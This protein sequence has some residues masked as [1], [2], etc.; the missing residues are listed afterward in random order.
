MKIKH[1][2][3]FTHGLLVILSLF[4]VVYNVWIFSGIESDA[5]IINQAGKLRAFSYNMVFIANRMTFEEESANP[6]TFSLNL[7]QKVEAFDHLLDGLSEE[8]AESHT[9]VD[10]PQ[11]SNQLSQ[12]TAQWRNVFKPNYM[13]IAKG[14]TDKQACLTIN[15]MI[16]SYVN[17]IDTMV[18]T[19]SAYSKQKVVNA[20]AVNGGLVGV[21]ILVTLYSFV[22]TNQRIRKPMQ[23]LMKA[24]K[25]LTLVDE[26]VSKKLEAL[27]TDEISEMTQYFNEMM[28][29]HLTQTLS[30]RSGLAKLNQML[31]RDNRRAVKLSLCFLDING[32][33]TV[34]DY[35]GHKYGDELIVSV[36]EGIKDEIRDGDFVI[37]MGGDEFLVV[38]DGI[39]QVNAENIWTRILDRYQ[40]IN[41][42]EL[43]P[44]QISVS[45]GIV[46]YDHCE[47]SEVDLLIKRADD[48]MYLEKKY[49]KEAL[50]IQVIRQI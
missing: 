32:L 5:N 14:L 40:C 26:T 45:H 38:F 9:L 48:K 42:Q 12:I 28:V 21:I 30:R 36:A 16:D 41:D 15:G 1:L 24:L 11:S 47:K 13:R 3:L 22:S 35:L 10:H 39:D 50:N 2:L 6:E 29:D 23:A 8:S 18:A 43:R 19:Y 17:A 27:Q 44:Y 20:L 49:F 46:E 25:E 34:N 4:I 33:K 7:L 37:R 31:R